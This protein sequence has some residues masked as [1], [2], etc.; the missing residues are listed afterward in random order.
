MQVVWTVVCNQ[1][2]HMHLEPLP[3]G[4]EGRHRALAGPTTAFDLLRSL[5]GFTARPPVSMAV[6]DKNAA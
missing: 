5:T 4:W 6:S 3:A 1:A 2:K